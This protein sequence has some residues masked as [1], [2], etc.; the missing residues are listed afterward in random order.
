MAKASEQEAA[1]KEFEKM[2][3]DCAREAGEQGG[4]EAATELA[5][6]AVEEFVMV[7]VDKAATEA[8]SAKGNEVFGEFGA[9]V[10]V[11]AGL[12]AGRKVALEIAKKLVAEVAAAEGKIVG[13][14]A[15]E[16]AGLAEAARLDLKAMS[17]EKVAS[18][19]SIF[20]E[21]GF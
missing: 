10:G 16:K 17:K 11:E 19:R 13:G 4:A 14:A 15:G 18:L 2:A 21:A 20:T 8:G 12:V 3:V 7:E 1:A 6:A 9:T 5:L